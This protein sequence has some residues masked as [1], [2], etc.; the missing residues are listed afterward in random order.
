MSIVGPRALTQAD[1]ERLGWNDTYHAV[2][3]HV[4]PGISGLA[5]LYGGHHRK[6]SWFWDKKYIHHGNLALDFGVIVAS[7]L[8]NMF[9]KTRVR[10]IIFRNHKLN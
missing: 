8:M 6:Y 1:I 5:Q 9:G 10:R 2:R 3:W 7:F 4:K